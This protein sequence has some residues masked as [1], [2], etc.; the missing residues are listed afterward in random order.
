M[1]NKSGKVFSQHLATELLV[2]VG[3]LAVVVGL[4]LGLDLPG[5]K[6]ADPTDNNYVP[7]PEWYFLFLFQLLKLFP[8]KLELVAIVIVPLVG[9]V[10]LF[11]LPFYDWNPVRHP[12]QRPV[13]TGAG[14]VLLT[15]VFVLTAWGADLPK[16]VAKS[17]GLNKAAIAA[18]KELFDR[19][20]CSMCH[21]INGQGQNVGPDLAGLSKR[22][23][24]TYVGQVL[25]SPQKVYPGTPMP[26]QKLT[27]EEMDKLIA[28]LMS[29][30]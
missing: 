14:V 15:F 6:L 4:A 18:G 13:A 19:Q 24:E 26:P 2:A 3:V 28:Y 5:D 12:K 9:L 7:R 30:E 29:L 17:I 25:Q 23:D 22:Y 20:Q 21:T 10:S 11:G 8:G 27:Q 1:K 16:A